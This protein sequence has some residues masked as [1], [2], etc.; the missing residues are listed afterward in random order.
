MTK[1]QLIQRR[2]EELKKKENLDGVYNRISKTKGIANND[3]DI[4]LGL[5]SDEIETANWGLIGLERSIA[6]AEMMEDQKVYAEFQKNFIG[7]N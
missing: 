7:S 2:E 5:L 3:R 6:E 1:E 4:I